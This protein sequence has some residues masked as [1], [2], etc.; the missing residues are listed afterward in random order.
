[1]KLRLAALLALVP[2]LGFDCARGSTITS[3]GG[4]GGAGA[5]AVVSGATAHGTT[6][7]SG[8]HSVGAATA[9]AGNTAAQ[10]TADAAST[11]VN[12]SSASSS[13]GGTAP[14]DPTPSNTCT[15]AAVLPSVSG[16]NGGQTSTKGAG[17]K[18]VAVHVTEDNSSIIPAGLSYTVTL[19]SPAGMIYDLS[20]YEGGGGGGPNCQASPMNG[21]PAGGSVQSVHHSWSD[22]LGSDDSRWINIFVNLQSGTD[23]NAQWSLLIQGNT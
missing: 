15:T 19:T 21:T 6:V 18:W 23:C 14:C 3:S 12:T 13:T 22:H 9:G 5:G 7:G 20:V 17:S 11:T 4:A 16:D 2:A 8:T 10:A 1:M